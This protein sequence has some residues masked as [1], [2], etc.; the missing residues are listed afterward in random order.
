MKEDKNEI[1]DAL[2]SSKFK[3]REIYHKLATHQYTLSQ[4]DVAEIFVRID[5]GLEPEIKHL[6]K[7]LRELL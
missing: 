3:L 1:L 6:R 2:S 4:K 5:R 7:E